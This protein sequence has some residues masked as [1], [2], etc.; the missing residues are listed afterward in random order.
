VKRIVL[1]GASFVVLIAACGGSGGSGLYTVDKTRACLTA[2][3]VKL[4]GP[5]DFVAT[6]ATG[7]ALR[8]TLAT[9]FV[10]IVFGATTSDADN[11]DQ[12]YRQFHAKNV[13]IDDVL[14]QDRNAV[15]LWHVHP[16][17]ADLAEIGDCLKS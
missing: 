16:A 8:A 5:L 11:I 17:D 9:N 10:T 13:G 1:I 12:A 2:K 6:T 3:H 4:G 15:L 7:G 14:R